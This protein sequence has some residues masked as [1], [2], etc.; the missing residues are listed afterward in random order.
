LEKQ[1]DSILC[2]EFSDRSDT[3]GLIV[4]HGMMY[5]AKVDLF[6]R[7][8]DS[9]HSAVRKNVAGYGTLIEELKQVGIIRNQ[10]IRGLE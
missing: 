8:E 7:I 1:F 9:F 3:I 10:V 5:A 6:K 4:L 2:E